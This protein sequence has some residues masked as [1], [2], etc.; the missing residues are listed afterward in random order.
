MKYRA[1]GICVLIMVLT[2]LT[3]SYGQ[4]PE[5]APWIPPQ[6]RMENPWVSKPFD[7][8][9]VPLHFPLDSLSVPQGYLTIP[10]LVKR[11][12]AVFSRDWSTVEISESV[13]GVVYSIPFITTPEAYFLGHLR[14]N[15][16]EAF[17]KRVNV[18]APEVK[19]GNQQGGRGRSIEVVGVDLGGLGRASLRVNGNVN[20]SGK[21]VFQNQDLVQSSINEVQNTHIEFD[22]KQNLSIEGKIGDRITVKMDQDSERDFD[23]ENNI[24]I[25]YQGKEDDIVQQV[26]AG[27]ISLSLPSTQYVTF[28]GKNKG[29]FGLKAISKLGPVNIT[30]IASIEQTKK[31]QQQYKGGSESKTQQIKD[32]EYL[33]NKYFFIHPWFRNGV[34][35]DSVTT[36]PIQ[37]SFYI[38]PYFPL[39]DGYHLPG[40][41]VVK[42]FELYKRDLTNDPS[43]DVGV[44]YIDPNR[45]DFLPDKKVD[46]NFIRL[47]RDVDYTLAEN[48]GYVRMNISV[49]NEVIGCTFDLVDYTS[50]DTVFTVGHQVSAEDSTLILLMLKTAN[51][52]PNDPNWDLMFKNV[53]SLGTTNIN[54]EGF[55]VRVV[56][57]RAT[58]ESDRDKQGIVYLTQFGL[59]SLDNN[60]H[61]RPDEIVDMDNGNI[62]NLVSG[63]LHFPSFF[64]FAS[65]DSLPG[66]NNNPSLADALGGG[67]MYTS[68]NINDIRDDSRFTIE[69]DY[70]NQS[71]TINLGFIRPEQPQDWTLA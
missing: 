47:E 1:L 35:S 6:F 22:Q 52:H 54:R 68:S 11:R 41:V 45:P 26:E 18:T 48:L 67:V 25:S 19:K 57:N 24:R 60:G 39:K 7:P 5:D 38:P 31:E 58:P 43:A 30:T 71:S 69:A 70:T 63:E 34:M 55:A 9:P 17:A 65:A 16:L 50:G 64:P 4:A 49:P 62:V 2:G 33:K 40:N 37:H 12:T 44:A 28:S 59:D 20:I 23:W 8:G 61:T 36:Y 29:L 42:N 13:N 56:N 53:Y 66:G 10:G 15:R 14:Q 51:P 27:N 32:Y 3:Q 21:A 46:G